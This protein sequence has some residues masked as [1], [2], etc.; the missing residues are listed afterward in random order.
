MGSATTTFGLRYPDSNDDVR[1]YEDIQNL[2]DD[3]ETVLDRLGT[4]KV[5]STAGGSGVTTTETKDATGDLAFTAV[6]GYTY[7]LNYVATAISG[8]DGV[9]IDVNLRN[10]GAGSP[11]NA[12]TQVTGGSYRLAGTSIKVAVNLTKSLA[13]PGD[14]A[15]GP[16]T[17]AAFYLRNPNGVTGA[18]VVQLENAGPNRVLSVTAAPTLA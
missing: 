5:S 1:P 17:V 14:I 2:A 3:V 12:S 13:C 8:A 10:G 16:Q 15:A 9:Y 7:T 18:N 6:S 11:T 4:K